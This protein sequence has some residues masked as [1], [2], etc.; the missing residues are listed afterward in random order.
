MCPFGIGPPTCRWEYP[1]SAFGSIVFGPKSGGG[2][3]GGGP[4]GCRC[5][6]L[7]L[8]PVTTTQ[9]GFSRGDDDSIVWNAPYITSHATNPRPNYAAT[10]QSKKPPFAAG[11]VEIGPPSRLRQYSGRSRPPIPA[12]APCPPLV[13]IEVGL[14]GHP[15]H[16]LPVSTDPSQS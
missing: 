7:C 15:R 13:R 10:R 4:V 11:P 6:L 16:T 2:G 8:D 5:G 14:A 9:G 1:H 3:G 12:P